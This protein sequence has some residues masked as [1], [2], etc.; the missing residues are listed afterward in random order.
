MF[1]TDD[2]MWTDHD[3]TKIENQQALF[4]SLSLKCFGVA[5][6]IGKGTQC[7]L[8]N[9]KLYTGSELN[10]LKF[11]SILNQVPAECKSQFCNGL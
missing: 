2:D 1:C 10:I 6:I 9:Q 5:G 8:L 11:T 7:S 4:L 3:E